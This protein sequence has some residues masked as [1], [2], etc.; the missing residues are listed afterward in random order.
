MIT[1][2][3]KKDK[4]NLYNLWKTIFAY[5]DGGFINYFFKEMYKENN[6]YLIKD[7]KDE[8]IKSGLHLEK[9]K[10][11]F[12][13]KLVEVGYLDKLFTVYKYRNQKLSETLLKA[14][15]K[16]LKHHSLFTIAKYNKRFDLSKYGFEI[17]SYKK[18]SKLY[19]KDLYNVDG[20][21]ISNNFKKEEL[22]QLYKDF[23]KHFNLYFIRDKDYY[24][25]YINVAKACKR[26]IY[27][28]R[29]QNKKIK[30]YMLLGY[31]ESEVEVLEIVYLDSTALLTLLNKAMGLNN[32]IYIYSSPSENFN[33]LFKNIEKQKIAHLM[34]KVNNQQL[35][36]SL[37]N[38]TNARVKS[39]KNSYNKPQH[40]G[41]L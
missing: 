19:R 41:F 12:N 13:N 17:L 9:R 33:L 15:L 27:V 29:D 37:F 22:L 1:K 24:K 8:M 16:E 5:E 21:S 40:A 38:S 7:A 2:A 28:S 18:K 10:L 36:N 30:G 4:N 25:D 34:I 11:Y 35:F 39:L 31:K 6:F 20:Y 14:V 26:E 23:T 32:Y 3:T